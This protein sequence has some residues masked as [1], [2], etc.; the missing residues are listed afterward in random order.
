LLERDGVAKCF[1]LSLESAGAVFGRVAADRS[2]HP[3]LIEA[4]AEAFGLLVGG[5][6][7]CQ[8]AGVVRNGDPE[9]LALCAWSATHGLSA[10]AVD[11]QLDKSARGL[12]EFAQAVIGNAPASA[13][14]HNREFTDRATN[15]FAE[16]YPA[17]TLRALGLTKGT[18]K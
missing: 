3:R 5:I 7:D 4:A 14:L 6:R 8:N 9:E 15:L 17:A 1:E 10:L 18:G 13:V 12:G 11:G 2:A 16:K